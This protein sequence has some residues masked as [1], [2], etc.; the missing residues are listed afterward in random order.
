MNLKNTMAL[1]K[2]YGAEMDARVER[3]ANTPTPSMR[4][5][6]KAAVDPN[7]S[8]LLMATVTDQLVNTAAR[9]QAAGEPA[10]PVA[11]SNQII[12]ITAYTTE[13]PDA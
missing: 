9:L 3:L 4:N 8:G 13:T 11:A 12:D 10:K 1:I 7:V 6:E 2:N 5:V